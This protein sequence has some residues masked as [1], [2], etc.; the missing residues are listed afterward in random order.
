M[1]RIYGRTKA[2]H[3]GTGSTILFFLIFLLPAMLLAQTT[4]DFKSKATG[5]WSNP[6]SWQR[7]SG[8]TWEDAGTGSNNPGQVPATSSIVT[9]NLNH[10]ISVD[11]ALAVCSKLVFGNPSCRLS[12]PVSG[13][14]L[15]VKGDIDFG[16]G[17]CFSSGWNAGAKLVLSG[18]SSQALNNLTGSIVFGTLEINKS[19]GVV[20]TDGNL[21]FAE[22]LNIAQGTLQ[23]DAAKDIQGD[24]TGP[25]NIIIASGSS[26]T[27]SGGACSIRTGSSGTGKIGNISVAGSL[28]IL[29]TSGSGINA[30]SLTIE[31]GAS[32][33]VNLANGN[34]NTGNTT[35]KYGAEMDIQAMSN[36]VGFAASVNLM[37][38]SGGL[39]KVKS[40]GFKLPGFVSLQGVVD[41]YDNASQNIPGS[42]YTYLKLSGS[43]TKTLN[44]SCSIN[45]NGTFEL[46]DASLSVGAFTFSASTTNTTILYT[47]ITNKNTLANEWHSGFRH[48]IIDKGSALVTIPALTRTLFGSLQLTSGALNIGAG[49]DLTLDGALLTNSG[50]TLEGTNTSDLQ[51]IGAGA[52]PVLIP[53]AGNISLRKFTIGGSRRVQMNGTDHVNLSGAFSVA[54]NAVFDN[55]GESE[56]LNNVGGTVSIDGVFITRDAQGFMGASSAIPG[57]IPTINPG[58]TIE[59]GRSGD[60]VVQGGTLPVPYQHVVFSGSGNKGL[61]SG[62]AVVTSITIKDDAILN[63]GSFT[64]GSNTAN[65]TMLNNAKYI[66]NGTG[67]KPDA[68]GTYSLGST[69]TI[70]FAGNAAVTLQDIRLGQTYANIIISGTN[71]GNNSTATSILLLNG[72]SF[73]VLSGAVFKVK[74]T[75]GFAASSGS[76]CAVRTFT[77]TD[78]LMQL[79][80][81]STIEYNGANQTITNRT[82][83]GLGL[84]NYANLVLSGTGTKTAPPI[85]PLTISEDFSTLAAVSFFHNYG[86]II[87][88]GTQAQYYKAV[89]PLSLYNFSNINTVAL[90]IDA[91]LRVQREFSLSPASVLQLNKD[92][93][94]RS[95]ASNTAN[96]RELANVTINYSGGKFVAERYI[97]TPRKWQL[98]TV[99]LTGTQTIRQSW[100]EDQAP[101]TGFGTNIS[102]P[103]GTGF[104]FSSPSYSMKFWEAAIGG[105]VN[106]NNTSNLIGAQ[107]DKGYYIFVRGDRTSNATTPGTVTVMRSR[108]DLIIGDYPASGS[109]AL[110]AGFNSVGNPYAS[111]IDFDKLVTNGDLSGVPPNFYLWDP[112]ATGDYGVGVYQVFSKI[113]GYKPLIPTPYYEA[114]LPYTSIQSGQAFFVNNPGPATGA[115]RFR[116]NNKVWYN[117]MV[118]RGRDSIPGFTGERQEFRLI[119]QRENMALDGT[120]WIYDENVA[121][122]AGKYVA[123]KMM[124]S[125][126]SVFLVQ[127]GEQRA[128]DVSN[129]GLQT[130]DSLKL[131]I[132]NLRQQRYKFVVKPE[133]IPAN[134]SAWLVDH[135]LQTKT[136]LSASAET[137]VEFDVTADPLSSALQ[138]FSIVFEQKLIA[139]PAIRSFTINSSADNN[140]ELN[141][142]ITNSS[143]IAGFTMLRSHDG[144]H[145]S[146]LPGHYQQ[147]SNGQFIVCN[148]TDQGPGAQEFYRIVVHYANGDSSLSSTLKWDRD[149]R[150]QIVQGP[151]GKPVYCLFLNQPTGRYSYRLYTVSG[152]LLQA[153]NWDIRSRNAQQELLP[154]ASNGTFIL[155]V[156]DV[157][158]KVQTLRFSGGSK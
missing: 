86:D 14:I 15:N 103:S 63:T 37:L 127:P 78:P 138:R 101:I 142:Q 113:L 26:L 105:F 62:N 87:F 91:E 43:G 157:N 132:S 57:I 123:R 120:A 6:A 32:V 89:Q 54:A 140:P 34:L 47:G 17:N 145:F 12:F 139:R 97:Q 22:L 33:T 11:N 76:S 2:K 69:T 129:R 106:I 112:A 79:F 117:N 107:R 41:F 153:G 135:F 90:V 136:T 102:G 82:S 68:G 70:E 9:I 151:G 51:I 72:G 150:I 50:G 52:T 144:T 75:N 65:L 111:T 125:G 38:N 83:L 92:I 5:N 118:F 48:L 158:G 84:S 154:L 10:N 59:Y 156:E 96:V 126:E 147:T 73:K 119:L 58:S 20:T 24:G 64:F 134:L 39:L 95:S 148:Y 124:N 40:T 155:T 1:E 121:A 77:A 13:G 137:A 110:P 115:I 146:N 94:L 143:A 30:T 7:Y 141:W 108:G 128:V 18:T 23:T 29:S 109:L 4:G 31:P 131:G 44:N 28:H 3:S 88:N 27:Q 55:G 104:D 46:E 100:Q 45:A 122:D 133:G 85:G 56:I 42:G 21:R 71:V 74:N 98:L 60:Q 80:P 114:G 19:F 93:V 16:T 116:E 81:G 67:T 61:V 25:N 152:Q 49:S 149:S 36:N 8:S 35:I 99:P 130:G 66:L 53:T